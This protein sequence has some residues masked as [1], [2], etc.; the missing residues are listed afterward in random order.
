MN[1]NM[2]TSTNMIL[3]T[4]DLILCYVMCWDKYNRHA[5]ICMKKLISFVGIDLPWMHATHR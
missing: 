3:F 1:H 2:E 4:E 5:L